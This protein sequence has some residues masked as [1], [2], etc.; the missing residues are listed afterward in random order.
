MRKNIDKYRDVKPLADLGLVSVVEE[1]S[2][3]ITNEI[4][5]MMEFAL[6]EH[7]YNYIYGFNDHSHNVMKLM[8]MCEVPIR[9][10]LAKQSECQ[11]IRE[12]RSRYCADENGLI[13]GKRLYSLDEL[14]DDK[15]SI[16][17]IL[18]G[19][20]WYLRENLNDLFANG[21]EY[22]N[23]F[24]VEEPVKGWI[25]NKLTP[26]DRKGFGVEINVTDHCNLNC[27]MC[28]HFSQLAEPTYINVETFRRDIERLGELFDHE[29][30][31]IALLGGEPL[32]HKEL[33][34]MVRLAHTVFPRTDLHIISNGLLLQKWETE[35]AENLWRVCHDNEARIVVT[36][37]PD[38]LREETIE[39][40]YALAERYGTRL[41][42]AN[43]T[44]NYSDTTIKE[45]TKYAMDLSGCVEKYEFVACAEFNRCNHLRNGRLYPCPISACHQIFN[46][47]F[48][49]N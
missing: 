10:Y 17:V 26:K 38:V 47:F 34:E 35:E 12:G 23:I 32:L 33:P 9:G 36:R 43:H 2:M 39:R 41:T 24:V 21:F 20:G 22:Q 19:S 4:K 44:D 45:S 6:D 15:R 37:Y 49:K 3:Y 29:I 7:K 18:G 46:D 40:L 5:A 28:N 1:M 13:N 16:G 42:I 30:R 11:R 31:Y 25:T 14:A 8:D 48:R 27:Q